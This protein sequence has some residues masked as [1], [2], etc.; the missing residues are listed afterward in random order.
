MFKIF[1]NSCAPVL[2]HGLLQDLLAVYLDEG[3]PAGFDDTGGQASVFDVFVSQ[4]L[5][6]FS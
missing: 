5:L 4:L 1:S 6:C 2:K 3:F